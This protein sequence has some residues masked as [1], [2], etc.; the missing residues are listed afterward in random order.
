VE[1]NVGVQLVYLKA[2]QS[3][4]LPRLS[5]RFGQKRKPVLMVNQ[6][7]T[8]EEPEGVLTIDVSESPETI[9]NFIKNEFSL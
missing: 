3:Q 8:L 2:S 9:V 7:E 6:F 5:E 1:G 4:I